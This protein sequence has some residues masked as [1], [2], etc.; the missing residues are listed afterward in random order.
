MGL[1]RSL[2]VGWFP[3]GRSSCFG[4]ETTHTIC[5]A[6]SRV[7]HKGSTTA[8]PSSGRRQGVVFHESTS[9]SDPRLRHVHQL[10]R[11]RGVYEGC[12]LQDGSRDSF[13]QGGGNRPLARQTPQHDASVDRDTSR[14][15]IML[16]ALVNSFRPTLSGTA[17]PTGA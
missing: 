13:L 6:E 12:V 7:E 2:S 16:P 4:R 8:D 10:G 17:A 1:V 14:H 3:V 9:S 11:I 5:A 15:P